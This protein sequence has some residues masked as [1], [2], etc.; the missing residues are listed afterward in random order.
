[1]EPTKPDSSDSLILAAKVETLRSDQRGSLTLLAGMMVF[2]VT[3]F[4]VI[5]MD[6]NMAIY[7]R[8][9]AQN[10]V[11]SAADSA[12]LWQARFC[13]LEQL[14]NDLHYDFDIAACAAEGVDDLACVASVALDI[15]QYV[16]FCEWAAGVLQGTCAV[17]Y[18]L[19]FVD[20]VQHLFYDAIIPFQQGI[21]DVAPF[22]VFG[23]ANANAYGS[24]ANSVLDAGA[25]TFGEYL[26]DGVSAIPGVNSADVTSAFG[27]I[28]NVIGSALNN[29]PIYAMPLDPD[30]LKLYVNTNQASG[31]PE[32]WN[33]AIPLIGNVAGLV[34][35][36]Q[37]AAM[38]YIDAL[39]TASYGP[40]GG[41]GDEGRDGSDSNKPV[42][43]WNDLYMYGNPGYMT[44]IAG[45]NSRSELANLGS[46]VWLNSS[47]STVPTGMYT[48][49]NTGNGSLTIPA[50][51]AIASSQIE[52]T[53][54]VCNGN[55]DAVPELIRV[56]FPTGTNSPGTEL[57]FPFTI[58]H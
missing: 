43:G 6:T 32:V 37:D 25:T 10:A 13:N 56:Y 50:Y 12:A 26:A 47:S 28:D 44:W 53:P 49:P 42:W 35:C 23:Y 22:M 4:A 33:E 45:V 46:L 27:K 9:V 18:T 5:A 11:D 14:L 58:Y 34:G 36:T 41:T 52:G 16:P 57:P 40:P 20:K 15:L 51:I 39:S 48:G 8:I 29:I 1:M 31:P 24:G 2:L 21:A 17:C 7:N 54:V 19:P 55:A 3:I 30:S 38:D